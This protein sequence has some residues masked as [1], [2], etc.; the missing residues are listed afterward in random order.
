MLPKGCID[1]AASIGL[2]H[3]MSTTQHGILN[4]IPAAG[5]YLLFRLAPKADVGIVLQHLADA[6]CR[7][8]VLVG[9]GPSLC[10]AATGKL[11]GDSIPGLRE[12]PALVGNGVSAPSTPQAAICWVQGADRGDVLHT[13]RHLIG[14]LAAV[15]LALTHD[16]DAFRHREGRDLSGYVDGTENPDG[17]DARDAAIVSDL[18]AGLDGS[19]FLALQLWHHDLKRFRAHPAEDQDAIIGRRVSDNTEIEDAPPSAHVKRTAQEGFDPEAFIVRRSMPWATAHGEGLVFAAFGASFDAFDALMNRM[20]GLDDGIVDALFTFTHP[21]LGAAF[22]CPPVGPD[23]RLNL[24][25]LG[26]S[27]SS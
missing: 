20:M 4:D 21:T 15:G 17:E 13:A 6:A 2:V 1:W 5:R 27:L 14:E 12:L 10:M 9:L 8:D 26:T 19:S 25:A 24:M 22:W 18:G 7:T 23:G 11:A 3:G 16:V